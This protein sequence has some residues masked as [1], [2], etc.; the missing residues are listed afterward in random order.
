MIHTLLPE[1]EK[2]HIRREYRIR[3]AIVL[4]FT[5][6]L[7]GLLGMASIFPAFLRASLTRRANESAAA[8]LKKQR[9][10]SGLS[11]IKNTVIQSQKMLDTLVTLS[12]SLK[13]SLIIENLILLRDRLALSSISVSAVSNTS[14]SILLQG[15]APTREDLISFKQRVETKIPGSNVNLPASELARIKDVQ[16][17][18]QITEPIK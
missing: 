7:A 2:K 11:S 9:T 13:T 5:L 3:A 12:H 4:C 14:L 16:F 6:A 8:T 10:D 17:T 15:I 18:V 1:N